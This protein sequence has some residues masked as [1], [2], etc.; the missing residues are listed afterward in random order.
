MINED[1]IKKSQDQLDEQVAINDDYRREIENLKDGL[2]AHVHSGNDGSKVLDTDLTLPGNRKIVLGNTVSLSAGGTPGVESTKGPTPAYFNIGSGFPVPGLK[3][4]YYAP[5]NIADQQN[6]QTA[7]R[8]AGISFVDFYKDTAN[9]QRELSFGIDKFDPYKGE[10]KSAQNKEAIELNLFQQSLLGGSYLYAIQG[11]YDLGEKISISAGGNKLVD[12]SKTWVPNQFIN[13]AGNAFVT[14]FNPT[15]GGY[16]IHQVETNDATSLTIKDT[17]VHNWNVGYA[18]YF[19]VLMGSSQFPWKHI[20]VGFDAQIKGVGKQ[21]DGFVLYNPKN[22]GNT[23]LSG[24]PR[25]IEIL[26]DLPNGT[27]APYYF[28]VYP[29]KVVVPG[30]ALTNTAGRFTTVPF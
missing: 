11:P 8:W 16:E 7:K 25:T 15:T 21:A 5:I 12:S 27:T 22:S 26:L 18:V 20:R 1:D 9:E 24:D 28:N 29:T 4:Y 13:G 14:V 23:I 17:W 19:P 6:I 10:I 30:W 3:G 2:Q